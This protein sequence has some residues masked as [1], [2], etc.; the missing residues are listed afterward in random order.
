MATSLL[1]KFCKIYEFENAN[2]I[3][4]AFNVPEQRIMVNLDEEKGRPPRP[5][6]DSVFVIIRPSKTIRMAVLKAYL[7]RQ[8]PFDN[9]VLEAISK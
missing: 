5:Q 6:L 2:S 4:C 8:M 3:R 1:G 7:T 9:S